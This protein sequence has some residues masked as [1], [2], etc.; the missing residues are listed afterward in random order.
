M[1]SAKHLM[2]VRA[3][4]VAAR[5][6]PCVWRL[7]GLC[8]V[9][10]RSLNLD[11]ICWADN[12]PSGRV[13]SAGGYRHPS[14]GPQHIPG[15]THEYGILQ[16]KVGCKKHGR[17]YTAMSYRQSESAVAEVPTQSRTVS[18]HSGCTQCLSWAIACPTSSEPVGAGSSLAVGSIC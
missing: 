3:V 11:L 13:H 2:A 7:F 4:F 9:M 12:A 15:G 14:M 10:I 16:S 6:W 8:L 17:E 18:A 1:S 5:A